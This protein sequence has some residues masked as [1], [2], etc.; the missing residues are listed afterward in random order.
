MKALIDHLYVLE[1]VDNAAFSDN[2]VFIQ[3][4]TKSDKDKALSVLPEKYDSRKNGETL[5]VI[6]IPIACTIYNN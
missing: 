2:R 4:E 1:N 3:F 6:E 5:I